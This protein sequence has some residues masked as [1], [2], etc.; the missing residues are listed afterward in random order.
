MKASSTR[1]DYGMKYLKQEGYGHPLRTEKAS[2]YPKRWNYAVDDWCI[3][4]MAE[5]MGRTADEAD[6]EKRG[7]YF[8]RYFDTSTKFMRPVLANGEWRDPFNPFVPADYTEGN[9][10]QYTWLVPQNVEKLISL[11]GGDK[12]FITKLDSLFTV[13]GSLGADAPPDISGLVGMYAQGNEPNH[14]IPYCYMT[15]PA[16]LEDCGEDHVA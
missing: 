7:E 16:P 9:A 2:R 12:R 8:T 6:Y 10:W 4:R 13:T 3:A 11:M 14:H 5:R 15:L 1:D